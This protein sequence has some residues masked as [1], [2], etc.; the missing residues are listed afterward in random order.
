M[1]ILGDKAGPMFGLVSKQGC[2]LA[3]VVFVCFA[4]YAS[5]SLQPC[6]QGGGGEGGEVPGERSGA[7]MGEVSTVGAVQAR[8][9]GRAVGAGEAAP[10]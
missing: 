4:L 8:G 3:Y 7:A 9:S 10:R 2:H 5:N 1:L 6:V